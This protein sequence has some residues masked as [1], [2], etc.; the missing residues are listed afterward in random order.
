MFSKYVCQSL[1]LCLTQSRDSMDGGFIHRRGMITISKRYDG[2]KDPIWAM[3]SENGR[4]I[5]HLWMVWGEQGVG[6]RMFPQAPREGKIFLL[7]MANIW[8]DMSGTFLG[9]VI[10]SLNL[11]LS[12]WV[13][14]VISQT[15][16]SGNQTQICTK[17][18]T[19]T[20]TSLE[21]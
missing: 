19:C 16:G 21:L 14:S 20:E 9:I 15:M 5:V 3:Q 4:S 1:I 11:C 12:C 8:K 13:C 7:G 10:V 2:N 18:N 6:R 17:N